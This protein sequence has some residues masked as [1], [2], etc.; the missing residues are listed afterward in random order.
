[1]AITHVKRLRP[2]GF[3]LIELLLASLLG[4]SSIMLAVHFYLSVHR[5][6]TLE[7]NTLYLQQSVA[8]VLRFIA[9]D[10]RRAGYNE[11]N[12]EMLLLVD[13]KQVVDVTDDSMRYVYRKQ[14]GYHLTS[15]KHDHNKKTLMLCSSSRKTLPH[16]ESC[17]QFYSLF[18]EQRINV[19]EFK[20]TGHYSTT[21]K[22]MLLTILL[23][24]DLVMN[25]SSV[26][27]QV[28][29]RPRSGYESL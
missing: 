14:N 22:G 28:T 12:N 5:V 2:G 23:S 25:N 29:V 16:L 7:S 9:D 20:A 27:M 3:S 15:I 4:A 17:N 26:S 21:S 13:A 11:R 1:M 6:V 10:I 24:A 18:D 19:I 8:D